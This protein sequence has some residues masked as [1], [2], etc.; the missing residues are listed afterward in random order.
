MVCNKCKKSIW[1][2]WRNVGDLGCNE[3][4]FTQLM[5]NGLYLPMYLFVFI[6]CF[7]KYDVGVFW[8]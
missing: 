6:K 2:Q 3:T 8:R 4:I 1:Y 7:D 5:L